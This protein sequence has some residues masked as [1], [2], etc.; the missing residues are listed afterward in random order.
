MSAGAG[1][2]LTR[3][4][5]VVAVSGAGVEVDAS[6]SAACTACAARAGCGTGALG[7]MLAGSE[8]LTLGPVTGAR[9][10]DALNVSMASGPFLLA[11]A[12]AW[13]LPPLALALAVCA[14]AALGLPD[15]LVAG[16]CLPV[17]TLSLVP[18][19]LAETR[20]RAPVLSVQ[21]ASTGAP[22]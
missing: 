5:R 6:R 2:A 20:R 8:R 11:A 17:L 1:R 19:R 18:L 12:L 7:E 16:L 15:P 10:G 3:R 14:F 4:L 9:P 13:L 22:E 21:L